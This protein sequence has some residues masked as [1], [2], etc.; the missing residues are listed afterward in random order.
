MIG[1]ANPRIS[2][3]W[4]FYSL[5][6]EPWMARPRIAII[7][8]FTAN[9]GLRELLLGT[10][11]GIIGLNSTWVTHKNYRRSQSQ[12]KPN[13]IERCKIQIFEWI[14]SEPVNPSLQQG[15]QRGAKRPNQT[16][17][18]CWFDSSNADWE[19]VTC[20]LSPLGLF[21]IRIHFCFV[22]VDYPIIILWVSQFKE[23]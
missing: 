16:C 13:I 7:Q 3:I 22:T 19:K 10:C 6:A 20:A 5:A 2:F 12:W 1:K 15:W 11:T 4:W 18:S 9:A 21:S 17:D 14:R 8:P 23:K